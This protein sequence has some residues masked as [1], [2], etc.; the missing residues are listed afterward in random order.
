MQVSFPNRQRHLRLWAKLTTNEKPRVIFDQNHHS[1]PH[2][3][4]YYHVWSECIF[5]RQEG[6][7]E[8]TG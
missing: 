3:A 8:E 7:P 4:L 1:K 5:E 6:V 2:Q